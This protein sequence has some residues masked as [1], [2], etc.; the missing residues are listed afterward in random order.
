MPLR[1]TERVTNL[2]E[3]LG[4][5]KPQVP[6]GM[7]LLPGGK[8]GENHQK[9]PAATTR[10]LRKGDVQGSRARDQELCQEL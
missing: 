8:E 10:E 5:T 9:R 1:D 3:P 4:R 7:G 6:A 2:P